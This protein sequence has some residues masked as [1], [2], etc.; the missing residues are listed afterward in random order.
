PA[1]TRTSQPA[2]AGTR[3]SQPAADEAAALELD[4]VL[5]RSPAGS[6]LLDDFTLSL[7]PGEIVGLYGVE[8][9]GQHTLGDLMSGLIIPATGEVRVGG[10]PVDLRRPG[11][12]H[13]AGVGVISEDRHRSGC[14][15]DMSV[16]DNL[17]LTDLAPVS[18]RMLVSRRRQLRHA[19]ELAERFAISCPSLDAPLRTLSGGNQQ[20]VVLARELAGRPSV[21]VAAQPTRGL[22]VGAIESMYVELRAAAARGVAVLLVST[23]LEEVMA[24]SDRIAVIS[25]GRM[26]GELAPEDAD[27]ES[28]GLLVGG[29]TLTG[30]AR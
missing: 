8:G 2:P 20:R 19:A 26:V 3:T 22:D 14:V 30:P 10:R 1:G 29:A 21:L 15:L 24:L 11:A 16:A 6:A 4:G 9:N 28:L 27:A 23:E 12:L 18:G 7:R 13:A 17:V 5:V 25:G